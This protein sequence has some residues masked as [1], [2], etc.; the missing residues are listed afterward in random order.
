[1]RR[2]LDHRW[3]GIGHAR[4]L[5]TCRNGQ[6]G[7][8]VPLPHAPGNKRPCPNRWEKSPAE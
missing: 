2:I 8:I 5:V 1:M 3:R 4:D 6:I 7:V